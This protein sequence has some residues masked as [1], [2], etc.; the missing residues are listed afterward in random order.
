MDSSVLAAP[1]AARSRETDG[2]SR[3]TIL[4]GMALARHGELDEIARLLAFLASDDAS[5]CTGGGYTA[6]GGLSAV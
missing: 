1:V 3:E 4:R 5:R 6:D 2:Q